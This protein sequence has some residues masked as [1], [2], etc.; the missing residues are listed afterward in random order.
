MLSNIPLPFRRVDVRGD[1]G[2][3]DNSF[4]P[5][6]WSLCSS[7]RWRFGGA[8]AADSLQ[9]C[10]FD[11]RWS[12]QVQASPVVCVLGFR[13]VDPWGIWRLLRARQLERV[14]EEKEASWGELQKQPSCQ[15]N[16]LAFKV[17]A[18]MTS[19]DLFFWW[20]GEISRSQP[21][22]VQFILFI[23][24]C[25]DELRQH[26]SM[27]A[28]QFGELSSHISGEVRTG[29]EKDFPY[30]QTASSLFLIFKVSSS[31]APSP[32]RSK[33]WGETLDGPCA[34]C[35]AGLL[36]LASMAGGA[37]GE[38]QSADCA[39]KIQ[40]PPKWMI[41]KLQLSHGT[42][43]EWSVVHETHLA[44]CDISTIP[45]HAPSAQQ[46]R[47]THPK[48]NVWSKGWFSPQ[49]RAAVYFGHTCIGIDRCADFIPETD[50]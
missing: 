27:P 50:K 34:M 29:S 33:N 26:W 39:P 40:E 8:V 24:V 5:L 22:V 13:F 17:G 11:G 4:L 25:W 2:P 49:Q 28:N 15:D 21:S 44:L 41:F 32:P 30:M 48:P 36:F 7:K 14:W 3:G 31:Y 45:F 9:R 6:G 20:V 18:G 35:G 12:F 43:G 37:R 46:I 19:T 42:V 38:I 10:L 23:L 47:W 1:H 16:F